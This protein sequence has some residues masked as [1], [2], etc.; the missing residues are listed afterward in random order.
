MSGARF[1]EVIREATPGEVCVNEFVIG[2]GDYLPCG[3]PAELLFR[4][5]EDGTELSP[6]LCASCG[7]QLKVEIKAQ[8]GGDAIL[9]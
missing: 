7:E 5:T 1:V 4:V 8:P 2:D 9:P 6:L 3:D